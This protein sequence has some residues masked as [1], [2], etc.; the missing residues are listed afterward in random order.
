MFDDLS[1]VKARRGRLLEPPDD[2]DK[3]KKKA[4]AKKKKWLPYN[5]LI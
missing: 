2:D 5:L 4:P 1:G 3:K